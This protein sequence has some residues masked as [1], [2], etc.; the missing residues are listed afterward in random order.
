MLQIYSTVHRH[1]TNKLTSSNDNLA[2]TQQKALPIHTFVLHKNFKPVDF[3]TKLKPL[4]IGPYKIQRH[5]SDVTYE[6]LSQDGSL[7]HTHRNH[8]IPY[9]PK[10]PLLFHI[11][12]QYQNLAPPSL[13]TSSSLI[14]NTDTPTPSLINN[15]DTTKYQNLTPTPH[16]NTLI[17]PPN[18]PPVMMI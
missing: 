1:I 18:T 16:P 17:L 10:E 14:T 9:Y 4:R 7:F 6:L 2:L 12:Q 15:P 13:P 11:I 3:S 5:L 8:I